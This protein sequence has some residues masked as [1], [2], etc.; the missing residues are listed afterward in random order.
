MVLNPSPELGQAIF[1]IEIMSIHFALEYSKVVEM[2][3]GSVS[4]GVE[5]TIPIDIPPK[6]PLAI[7]FGQ[8]KTLLG[9]QGVNNLCHGTTG[10]I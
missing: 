8:G 10:G 2:L 7:L 3:D 9:C 1:I 4:W 5:T 6:H